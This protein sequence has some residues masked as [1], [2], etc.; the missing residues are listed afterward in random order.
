MYIN[1]GVEIK[2]VVLCKNI[3]EKSVRKQRKMSVNSLNS[4]VINN[5]I[6]NINL[7]NK[8]DDKEI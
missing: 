3:L 8:S 1:K 2:K 7:I 5:K 6:S 4:W